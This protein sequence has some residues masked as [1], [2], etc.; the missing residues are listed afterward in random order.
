MAKQNHTTKQKQSQQ[1]ETPQIKKAD[2]DDSQNE[3]RM[4]CENT[5]KI[6][7]EGTSSCWNEHPVPLDKGSPKESLL[8]RFEASSWNLSCRSLWSAKI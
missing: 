3:S 1:I 2:T 4:K 8:I 5:N 6:I 7:T